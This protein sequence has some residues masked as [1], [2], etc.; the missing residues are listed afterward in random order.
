MA[1]PPGGPPSRQGLGAAGRSRETQPLP[2]VGLQ[3]QQAAV[4]AKK[5]KCQLWV[6]FWTITWDWTVTAAYMTT[7]YL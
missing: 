5:G 7:D 1:H 6:S 2:T 4:G 3:H